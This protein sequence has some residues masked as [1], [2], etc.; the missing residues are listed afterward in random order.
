MRFTFVG[1]VKECGCIWRSKVFVNWTLEMYRFSIV[2]VSQETSFFFFF[3]FPGF[4]CDN[5]Y[6]QY[7]AFSSLACFLFLCTALVLI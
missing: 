3:S 1:L 7:Q 2:N 6:M 5:Y 4:A